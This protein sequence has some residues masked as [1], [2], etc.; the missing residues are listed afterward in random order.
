MRV[1]DARRIVAEARD[2]HWALA[3]FNVNNME[4]AQAVVAAAE[5]A[6]VPAM[7]QVSPGAIDYA[8]YDAIRSIV[9]GEAERSS[10]PILV[11]L[12]HCRDPQLVEQ[13]IDDGFSSVMFDGSALPFDENVSATARLTALAH[14]RGVAVEA[15]LGA[16]GGIE[17]M[18]MEQAR[19]GLTDAAE[20]ATFVRATGI[21]ILAAQV[22]TLHR[23]PNESVMLD[24]GRISAI[25]AATGCALALH[26]GS[27][28]RQGELRDAIAGGVTKINISSRVGRAFAAGIRGVWDAEPEQLDLRRYLGAGRTSVQGL[29][30]QYLELSG[31]PKSTARIGRRWSS[32]SDEP[33]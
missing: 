30:A 11:H 29:A 31:A 13:A 12:D 4:T 3:A 8:G 24:R 18:T 23:M 32:E 1:T 19:Q 27:G 10:V 26:G 20:A 25:A 33:E 22:G 5:D 6:A 14:D 28:V 9:F 21:D 7:L 2:K 17:S 16:I 15:E